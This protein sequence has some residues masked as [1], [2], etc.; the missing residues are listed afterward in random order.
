MTKEKEPATVEQN[1]AHNLRFIRAKIAVATPRQ[2]NLI[3][4]LIAGL[5]IEGWS[6]AEY[7][8]TINEEAEEETP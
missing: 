7:N 4:G 6:S 2:L 8:R 3:A 5:G 1:K